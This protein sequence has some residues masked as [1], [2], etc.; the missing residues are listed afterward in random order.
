[1]KEITFT[2]T[3][4]VQTTYKL[5]IFDEELFNN[6]LEEF[7][8]QNEELFWSQLDNIQGAQYYLEYEDDVDYVLDNFQEQMEEAGYIVKCEEHK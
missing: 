6:S 8:E 5:K 3:K 7:V 4:E 1:M 2:V